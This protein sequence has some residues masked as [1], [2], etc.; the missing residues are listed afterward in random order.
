MCLSHARHT[1]SLSVRTGSVLKAPYT[2]EVVSRNAGFGAIQITR[3]RNAVDKSNQIK[4][5]PQG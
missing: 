3:A 1:A 5:N 2:E 4:L